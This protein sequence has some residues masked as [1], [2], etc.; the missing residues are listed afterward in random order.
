[1][2]SVALGT[3]CL[4]TKGNLYPLL[5]LFSCLELLL[6]THFSLI[7]ICKGKSLRRAGKHPNTR[8]TCHVHRDLN[9]VQ[10]FADIYLYTGTCFSKL[11]F[12]TLSLQTAL[13]KEWNLYKTA[14]LPFYRQPEVEVD[15]GYHN[16]S[17][18][19]EV[20]SSLGKG[21]EAS[22]NQ[23]VEKMKGSIY[24]E[25]GVPW[26]QQGLWAFLA[27]KIL[28]LLDLGR[29]VCPRELVEFFT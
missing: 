15:V 26:C 14:F 4:G 10:G 7:Q 20:S 21:G 1:M 27:F 18:M 19:E 6:S 8:N 3:L 22:G 29:S 2:V 25:G 23:R 17:F 28:R 13:S 5:L 11:P 16:C 24:R 9:F 12:H